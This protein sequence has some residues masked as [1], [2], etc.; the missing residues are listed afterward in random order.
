MASFRRDGFLRIDALTDDA[1]VEDLLGLYDELFQSGRR[2]RCR[3]PHRI[4]RGH[5]SCTAAADRQPRT[6]RAT[7]D[8]GTG[9]S[10]CRG[11]RA[12]VAG[13]R[14][15]ADRQP[16]HREAGANRRRDA[17]APGRSVLGPPLRSPCREHLARAATGHDRERLH[18][19][20]PRQS[21]WARVTARAAFRRFAWTA[22]E[23]DDARCCANHLRAAGGRGDRPRWT[24][25]PQRRAQSAPRGRAAHWCSGS[26]SLRSCSTRPITIPGNDRNGCAKEAD[27]HAATWS[28]WTR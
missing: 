1:E 22:I 23:R 18:E 19:L 3:R 15:R 2:L 27:T 12:A 5:G 26:V 8:S 10:Q 16:R 25:A 28:T 21:S 13:I 17:V 14:L 20:Y 9:V 7:T 24:N 11:D 6:L 4:E